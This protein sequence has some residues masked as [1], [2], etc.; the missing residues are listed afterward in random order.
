[1]VEV[2]GLVSHPVPGLRKRYQGAANLFRMK[3]KKKNL[4]FTP[5]SEV[6]EY[7]GN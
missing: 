1:M 3:I 2:V 6:E 7:L 5:G 4:A